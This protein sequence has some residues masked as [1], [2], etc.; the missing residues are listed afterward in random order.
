M[1]VC[2]RWCVLPAICW[3]H[4]MLLCMIVNC[5]CVLATKITNQ[6]MVPCMWL[7]ICTYAWVVVVCAFVELHGYLVSMLCVCCAWVRLPTHGVYRCMMD[8]CGC[9]FAFG[10]LC[11]VVCGR[12]RDYTQC[13]RMQVCLF[14]QVCLHASVRGCPCVFWHTLRGLMYTCLGG[15]V[16]VRICV[17]LGVSP[18]LVYACMVVWLHV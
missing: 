17:R 2:V 14:V 15:H 9:E 8:V 5:S 16:V 4:A 1:C 3:M 18:P 13:V 7:Q 10:W 11:W 6:C 12:M